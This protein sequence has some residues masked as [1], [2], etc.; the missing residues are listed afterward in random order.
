MYK[1]NQTSAKM[2]YQM[3]CQMNLKKKILKVKIVHN[4]YYLVNI[5]IM[6]S[7]TFQLS[8]QRKQTVDKINFVSYLYLL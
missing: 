3:Y 8:V 7:K 1:N 6:F 5:K 2:N 4:F